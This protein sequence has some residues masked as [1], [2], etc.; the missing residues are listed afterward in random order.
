MRTRAGPASGAAREVTIILRKSRR[1]FWGGPSLCVVPWPALRTSSCAI[2][3]TAEDE[4]ALT[5]E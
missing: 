2:V 1:S 5:E 3:Y 4:R